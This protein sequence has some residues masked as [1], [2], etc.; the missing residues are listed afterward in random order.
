MKHADVMI[1]VNNKISPKEQNELLS[2]LINTEGV[3]TPKFSEQKDHLLLV[4][5]DS[6]DTNSLALL[7]KVKGKGYESQLVGL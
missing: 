6:A 5:Y 1:H 3:I 7:N 4:A 2:Q